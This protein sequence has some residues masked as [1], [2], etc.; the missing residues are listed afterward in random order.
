MVDTTQNLAAAA[1][2]FSVLSFVVLVLSLTLTMFPD[3]SA[4]IR[5]RFSGSSDS[6]TLK[7]V[8]AFAGAFSPDVTLLSGFISDIMNG[9]FRYSVTSLIGI[10]SV[11]LHWIVAGFVYG[12][13]RLSTTAAA[14]ASAAS[15]LIGTGEDTSTTTGGAL[16]QYIEEKFNP[17]A[18]RG[19]GMFDIPQSPMGMAALSSVFIVY[20]LDMFVDDKRTKPVLAGYVGA[21]GVLYALNLFAYKEF[22]CYGETYTDIA[23]KTVLPI[24][25]GLVGGIV[26]YSVIKSTAPAFLPLDSQKVNSPSMGAHGTCAPPNDQDQFVCD[27]YKDGKRVSTTVV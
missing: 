20:F 17:C 8:G 27:A 4:T 26:G 10:L 14:A 13:P 16:P 23:K 6:S 19:L 5:S 7:I 21:S 11:I 22:G 18:V 3:F 1:L 2:T 25:I 15:F 9:S 24:I 12:F